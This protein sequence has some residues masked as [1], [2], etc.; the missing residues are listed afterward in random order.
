MLQNDGEPAWQDKTYTVLKD[1]KTL[2]RNKQGRKRGGKEGDAQSSRTSRLSDLSKTTYFTLTL[3]VFLFCRILRIGLAF[4]LQH[5]KP[6]R[7]LEGI[8]RSLSTL[9]YVPLDSLRRCLFYELFQNLP[10]PMGKSNNGLKR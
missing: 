4:P 7:T 5:F 9:T 8:L 1:K 2:D 6:D 10:T 3:P